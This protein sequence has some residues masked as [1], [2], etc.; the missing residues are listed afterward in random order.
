[1]RSRKTLWRECAGISS[2]IAAL[3]AVL[4]SCGAVAREAHVVPGSE[5]ATPSLERQLRQP[6]PEI[7]KGSLK[8]KAL[9]KRDLYDF[10]KAPGSKFDIGGD[11][12]QYAVVLH[13]GARGGV[14][15]V[16]IFPDNRARHMN[17]SHLK[18]EQ[19]R[20]V[21]LLINYGDDTETMFG[22]PPY[23]EALWMVERV[24]D[25]TVRSFIVEI[26]TFTIGADPVNILKES[27]FR[28]CS[29]AAHTRAKANFE[30]KVCSRNE[31]GELQLDSIRH[32]ARVVT[33]PPAVRDRPRN[34]ET[35]WTDWRVSVSTDPPWVSCEV[36]CCTF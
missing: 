11:T 34:V 29:H 21:A 3:V 10:L 24:D 32:T 7:T 20:V 17:E 6:P 36:G 9:K 5:S 12:G 18:A 16:G 30:T 25:T 1:M 14:V 2:C 23:S 8:K 26:P 28:R 15:P 22:I 19:G 27:T 13:A 31:R 35:L 4:P 33:T